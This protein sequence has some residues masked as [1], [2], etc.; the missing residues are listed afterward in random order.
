MKTLERIRN[1]I[2][3]SLAIIFTFSCIFYMFDHTHFDGYELEE[4]TSGEKFLNRL[5]FT[6]TTLSSTGYGDIAPGSFPVKLI[7]ILLQYILIISIF[8]TLSS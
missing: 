7:S 6:M 3:L 4:E 5:Y 8:I 2:F 1:A